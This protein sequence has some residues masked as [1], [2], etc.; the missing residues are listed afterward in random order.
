ME[1]RTEIEMV[2]I[3]I[4][5]EPLEFNCEQTTQH[6]ETEDELCKNKIKNGVEFT[7]KRSDTTTCKRHCEVPGCTSNSV[8]DRN[9]VFH[10]LPKKNASRVIVQTPLGK[11][12]KDRLT[13]WLERCNL[14]EYTTTYRCV[15]CSRHFT[16]D[17][18]FKSGIYILCM[19]TDCKYLNLWICMLFLCSLFW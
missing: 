8:K 17:D 9:L 2:N 12:F 18:Y 1:V 13:V 19:L 10:M 5:V 7:P 11:I 15:I 14:K 6:I 16:E 4:K 3:P